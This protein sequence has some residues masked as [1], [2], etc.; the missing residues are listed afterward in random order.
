MMIKPLNTV[1]PNPCMRF[2]F[3]RVEKDDANKRGILCAGLYFPRNQPNVLRLG[4]DV[5]E[6]KTFEKGVKDERVHGRLLICKHA[7]GGENL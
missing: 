7:D 4:R 1:L 2:V 5:L 6:G 3:F